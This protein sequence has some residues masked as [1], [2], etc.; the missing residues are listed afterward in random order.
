[1]M[2]AREIGCPVAES[3]REPETEPNFDLV[4]ASANDSAAIKIVNTR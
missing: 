4:P 3:D 2:V 1:M